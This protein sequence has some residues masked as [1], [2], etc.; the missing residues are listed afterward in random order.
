[1]DLKGKHTELSDILNDSSKDPK[2]S[3]LVQET[4]EALEVLL[5]GQLESGDPTYLLNNAGSRLGR[6]NVFR[7]MII[8]LVKEGN[9]NTSTESGGQEVNINNIFSNDS[10]GEPI[11]NNNE[12]VKVLLARLDKYKKRLGVN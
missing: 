7:T 6:D 11:L 12:T 8:E 2:E 4:A 10:E 1:M 9:F 5:S 3:D